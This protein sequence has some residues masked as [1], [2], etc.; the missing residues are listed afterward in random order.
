MSED[1][2]RRE[3]LSIRKELRDNQLQVQEN[4][5]KNHDAVIESISNLKEDTTIKIEKETNKWK[6]HQQQILDEYK[7]QQKNA[8]STY[9]WVIR[10]IAGVMII[11]FGWL[12]KDHFNL[13]STTMDLKTDFG[14]VLILAP[15]DH[16][17]EIMFE[18]IKN[19][20]NP[21]RGSGN[22]NKKVTIN[23]EGVLKK[24]DTIWK[25]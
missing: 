3:L 25:L 2:I 18:E 15:E 12:A 5:Q 9:K 4:I 1:Q 7:L 13:K 21:K 11:F 16:N 14:Y 23:K 24:E 22:S 10:W 17:K 20:Y 19:K 8:I 6:E